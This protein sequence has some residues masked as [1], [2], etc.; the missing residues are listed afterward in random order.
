MIMTT[1]EKQPRDE[2]LLPMHGCCTAGM[3]ERTGPRDLDLDDEP[4]PF[5]VDG[6]AEAYW[7][8]RNK[9]TRLSARVAA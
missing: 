1:S 4:P 2:A 6:D 9:A 3:D 8:G 5:L 7:A